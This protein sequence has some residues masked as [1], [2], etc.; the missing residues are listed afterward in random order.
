MATRSV[1]QAPAR[2]SKG[3]WHLTGIPTSFS[4][5]PS[6][7]D[8]ESRPAVAGLQWN[9]IAA[10]GDPGHTGQVLELGEPFIEIGGEPT[11]R[12]PSLGATP[13]NMGMLVATVS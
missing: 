3:I 10:N 12:R 7:Q 2:G 1:E 13:G 11:F 6:F 5:R 4:E 8:A 9:R